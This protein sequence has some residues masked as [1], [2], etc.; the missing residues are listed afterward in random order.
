M[1]VSAENRVALRGEEVIKHLEA[2]PWI[3]QVVDEIYL[4][5]QPASEGESPVVHLTAVQ[6]GAVELAGDKQAECVV[7]QR[8]PNW[9]GLEGTTILTIDRVLPSGRERLT[10][11]YTPGAEPVIVVQRPGEKELIAAD[12]GG[13]KLIRTVLKNTIELVRWP[14]FITR[15]SV[16][17]PKLIGQS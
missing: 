4:G 5:K 8:N 12:E 15:G 6:K 16:F 10:A 3:G 11:S 2:Y 9:Y 14:T 13:L 1:G 7:L 17:S